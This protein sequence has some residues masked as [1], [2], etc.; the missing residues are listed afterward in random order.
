MPALTLLESA[1]YTDNKHKKGIY[2]IISERSPVSE[3]LPFKQISGNAYTYDRELALSGVAF[4]G[5]NETYTR[6]TGVINP[7]T[8][9]VVI[10]GGEIFIDRFQLK[11]SN[12]YDLKATQWAMKAKAAS[13]LFSA[14]FFEGDSS[15][16]V[17][18][19]DGLRN[20]LTGSQ[21]ILA[22]TNGAAISLALLDQT[23]DTVVGDTPGNKVAY[24]NKR[25][26]RD[27]T[28]LGRNIS[29]GYSMIDTGNDAFGRQVTKYAGVPL[30][31]VERDDN[32]ATL[33]DFDET[34]G[35]SNVTS[36]MYVVRF[37]EEFVHG[38]V[39][40]GSGPDVY[41][42]NDESD[43]APGAIGRIDWYVG[44]CIVH[45]RGAARLRGIL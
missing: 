35:S 3:R 5:V 41:D 7:E 6:S 28:N 15:A 32:E 39:A 33:L 42:V 34:A 31:I 14:T 11:T 4:R 40:G 27:I 37:G 29:S 23:L 25:L 16:N 45:P 13:L 30:L 12:R 1:K 44:L 36:S 18:E 20:R 38:I 43:V 26:R 21:S 8:E 9:R 2:R 22:G 24:L 19:F 10:M 17:R